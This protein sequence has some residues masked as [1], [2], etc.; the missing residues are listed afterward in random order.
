MTANPLLETLIPLVADLSREL[1]DGERYRRLLAALRQLFPC[2]AVALLRLDGEI[3]VPLAVEGLSPDTLGRRFRVS[4]HPRL[5]ALLE[6]AG[7]TRF[8]ADCGLP[9]PYDGLVDGLHG[10]LEVH[11][12]LGCP[13]YLDE[14][15]WGLLT[16]DSLDP[17][18]FGRLDLDSLDAFASLA[19]ATV[20]VSQRISGLAQ[21][22]EAERQLTELYKQARQQPRELVGQSA[23]L[24]KLQDEI[25]LVGDSPLTVL[26]TGETGVG[27]ELVAE[28][29]HA[30]SPR[31][32]R[33]LVSINCAALPD[34][35]V[36]SELFG[37]VRGAFSGAMSERSGKFELADGGSLFLDEVGELPLAIQ[38]KLLRVLQSGQLQRVGSDRE[39]RVD[40]RVI[41]AT[42]RDL[43]AEVRAG[44]FRADLYHRLSVYPLPVPPLRERGRDVL[45]LAGYFLEENRA[46][47]GLRSLRLSAEAQK[48]LL[49]HDWPGN[50]RELEHLIGRASIKALARHG[51][52]PRILSLDVQDLDLPSS[53]TRAA[54]EAVL[55]SGEPVPEGVELRTAVDAF[56]R[57]LIEQCL[58]RHQGKWADAARELGVDRANLSRLAKRLG[59]K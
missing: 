17:A 14:Q 39:H 38:A 23:A 57:Q 44:R 2:D 18:S 26:I 4:E 46:R 42:N 11:D 33:P 28:A 51:E 41:A 59:I 50:V 9:D 52:R 53:E 32:Q 30:A 47:L 15:L 3:L 12:C 36:E 19:A 13:L 45:L 55:A 29:I 20:K 54:V 40:V 8:A 27:K 56:Q 7:P 1:D 25:R 34:A 37:H 6:H 22:V 24:R 35:L 58:A 48:A 49:G 16:L 43:A 31:A 5:A 10:H 21:R